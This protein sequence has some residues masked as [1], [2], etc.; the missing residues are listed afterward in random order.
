MP[1]A[2]IEGKDGMLSVAYG[3]A[4]LAACIALAKE[5]QSLKEEIAASKGK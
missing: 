4:A 3:N 5:V 1:E 2:I